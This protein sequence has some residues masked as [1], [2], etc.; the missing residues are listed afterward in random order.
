MVNIG[1][2][3]KKVS[4]EHDEIE[5]LLGQLDD[6]IMRHETKTTGLAILGKIVQYSIDHIRREE[7]LMDTMKYNF[8]REHTFDHVQI[9]EILT[10]SLSDCEGF[11]GIEWDQFA[12]SIREAYYNHI[13]HFD[14]PFI[15]TLNHSR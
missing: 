6:L 8:Y 3:T 10:K 9:I 11:G 1:E 7:L 5:R 15:D 2:M 14:D 12:R 13:A 4:D